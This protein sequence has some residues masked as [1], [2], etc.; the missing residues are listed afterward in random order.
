MP[1]A[2]RPLRD[3]LR[4]VP[5]GP[6]FLY[7]DLARG[8]MRL[9]FRTDPGERAGAPQIAA[10]VEEITARSGFWGHGLRGPSVWV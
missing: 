10:I 1:L 2:L 5:I 4:D 8:V 9:A 7:G 3:L 6:R